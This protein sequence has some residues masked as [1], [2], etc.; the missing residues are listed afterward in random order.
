MNDELPTVRKMTDAEV[1]EAMLQESLQY[2]P[3]DILQGF[4]ETWPKQTAK[5]LKTLAFLLDREMQR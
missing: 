2:V 5:L 3:V 1:F 4:A